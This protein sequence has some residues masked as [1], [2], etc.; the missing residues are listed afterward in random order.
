M[1]MGLAQKGQKIAT[2]V[3][4]IAVF[5][6]LNVVMVSARLVR[7]RVRSARRTAENVQQC[8]EMTSVRPTKEKTA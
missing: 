3:L 4:R 5:A 1:E 8:A 2:T 7:K 6:Q